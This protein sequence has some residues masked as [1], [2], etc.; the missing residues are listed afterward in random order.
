M[1]ERRTYAGGRF[2]VRDHGLEGDAPRIVGYA[3]VFNSRS[4]DLGGFTEEVAPGAFTDTI[5]T[6][7]ITALWNH[8]PDHLLGRMV[9]GT[10]R[11]HEDRHGLFMEILT[12]DTAAGHDLVTLVRRGDVRGAS[13]GFQALKDTWTTVSGR[14]L[15]TLNKVKLFDIS[16]VTN[17]AYLGTDVG[18]VEG[19]ARNAGPVSLSAALWRTDCID[20]ELGLRERD[21]TAKA[22]CKPLPTA[23][24]PTH[25]IGPQP[26][27]HGAR[28]RPGREARETPGVDGRLRIDAHPALVCE[29]HLREPAV[30]K[31]RYDLLPLFPRPSLHLR[32]R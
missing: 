18:L 26:P 1:I 29:R 22:T 3:A 23:S 9:A 6:D 14:N 24:E 12:P 4:T 13:F 31:R 10:L 19:G 15:R 20:R 27:R 16:P 8:Q 21:S 25:P 32:G 17:P 30:S 28:E 2:Q 5:A 11:L 7:D